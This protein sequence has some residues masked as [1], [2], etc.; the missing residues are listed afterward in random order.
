MVT[1]SSQFSGSQKLSALGQKVESYSKSPPESTW[2]AAIS[3]LAL[4]LRGSWDNYIPTIRKI[5]TANFQISGV[6]SMHFKLL[7][8]SVSEVFPHVK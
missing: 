5:L 7:F 3:Y 6:R 4:M 1:V 8:I 2:Q